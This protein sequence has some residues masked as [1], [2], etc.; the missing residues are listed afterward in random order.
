VLIVQFGGTVFAVEP[1]YLLDWLLI[2]AGTASVLG[3]A[4][5]VRLIRRVWGGRRVSPASTSPAPTHEK[6]SGD[7]S[8]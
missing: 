6:G 1:L 5:L 2:A 4:E 3:Y 8:R 7:G